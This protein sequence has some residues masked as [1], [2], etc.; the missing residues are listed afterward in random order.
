MDLCAW[1]VTVEMFLR[2]V[3]SAVLSSVTVLSLISILIRQNQ[4]HEYLY[5]L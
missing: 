2:A 4:Y 3:R 1:K 5:R